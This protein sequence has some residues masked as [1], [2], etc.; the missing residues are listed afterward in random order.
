MRKWGIKKIGSSAKS[1]NE[2]EQFSVN[3]LYELFGI[4]RSGYYK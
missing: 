2:Q 4:S 3:W 1:F